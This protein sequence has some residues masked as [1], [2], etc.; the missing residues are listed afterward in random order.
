MADT[1]EPIVIPPLRVERHFTCSG[2]GLRY[3]DQ[4]RV[5]ADALRTLLLPSGGRNGISDRD[6]PKAWW[7][8]QALF[9][10]FKYTKTMTIAHVRAQIEDAL[11][12]KNKGL[13]VPQN[14]LDLEYKHNKEFRELNAQ[15]RDKAGMG[16]KRKREAEAGVVVPKASKSKC[17]EKS[18]KAK[19]E[20]TAPS[21]KPRIK[22]AGTVLP[23]EAAPKPR[24]KQTAKKTT[25]V[26][27]PQMDWM[28]V[29]VKPDVPKPRTKQTAKRTVQPVDAP[30]WMD[31]DIKPLPADA[32][33]PRTKQI[34][35]K[36]TQPVDIPDRWD[37]DVKLP[38]A[39][40][41]KARTKQIARKTMQPIDDSV[42][43]E[44]YPKTIARRIAPAP[45]AAFASSSM[46]AP[47]VRTKQTAR[48]GRPFPSPPARSSGPRTDGVSGT[49]AIDCP[50]ISSQWDY[51][52]DFTLN[53][54]G[55]GATLEGEFELGLISGLLRC[56]RVEQRGPG[57]AYAAVRWAGQE[58]E[59][60]VCTPDA[61][62][63]GYIKFTGDRL[64]GKLNNVPACGDVDF[65]GQWV[66]AAGRI[67]ASWDA[68][69]EDAYERANRNRWH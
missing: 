9:Y 2:S 33:K 31:V 55:R 67:M 5:S 7:G 39:D 42:L 22:E 47:P 40:V 18:T 48:R 61:G 49:W 41:P 64:K 27:E 53:I 30:S 62:R 36:T 23:A 8:A 20:P 12:D 16:G 45:A 65:E 34:A 68:Y 32:P 1:L 57:G 15:V 51:M 4:E 66:G 35:R 13:H 29:D 50:A 25:R 60:P 14:I 10:G 44:A 21:K 6:R 37:V 43:D 54:V 46:P 11:R 56:D 63:S 19:A 69:D 58:N 59:G 38:P 3:E 26:V 52:E 28:D 17:A 24:T